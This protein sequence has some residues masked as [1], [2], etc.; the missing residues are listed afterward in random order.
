[1][2]NR[3]VYALSSQGR[4]PS[5]DFAE[6]AKPPAKVLCFVSPLPYFF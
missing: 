4:P 6:L 2:A 1:V 5:E 3:P